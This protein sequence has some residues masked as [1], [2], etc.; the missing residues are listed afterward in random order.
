MREQ[1]MRFLYSDQE[2]A[3][4]MDDETFEQEVIFWDKIE[5]IRQWLLEDTI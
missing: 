3:T 4:F 5:N 2:G 1:Q